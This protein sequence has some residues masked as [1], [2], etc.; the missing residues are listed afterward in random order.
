MGHRVWV[1]SFLETSDQEVMAAQAKVVGGGGDDEDIRPR[2][3]G[4]P[5]QGGWEGVACRK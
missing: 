1:R 5:G 2:G 3:H 4:S